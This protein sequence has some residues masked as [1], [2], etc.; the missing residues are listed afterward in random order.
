LSWRGS[1]RF[2]FTLAWLVVL[3]VEDL[4]DLIAHFLALSEAIDQS[5]DSLASKASHE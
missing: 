5:A 2:G 1:F 3:L 4:P